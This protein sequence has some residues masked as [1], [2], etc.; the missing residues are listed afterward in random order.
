MV[1]SQQGLDTTRTIALEIEIGLV[2]EPHLVEI[3]GLSQIDFETAAF[4]HRSLDPGFVPHHSVPTFGLSA[5]QRV[6]R[7]H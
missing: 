6:L 2:Y 3:D 7:L 4:L 5:A 1:P